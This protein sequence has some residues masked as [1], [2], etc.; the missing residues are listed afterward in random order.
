MFRQVHYLVSVKRSGIQSLFPPFSSTVEASAKGEQFIREDGKDA[1]HCKADGRPF[2]SIQ[3]LKK[4]K[5]LDKAR[6]R[7]LQ[8]GTLLVN[9]VKREDAGNYTCQITQTKGYFTKQKEIAVR[10][11]VTGG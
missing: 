2:P 1:L 11:V 9:S 8:N 5:S 10:V 4:G 3:W 7:H 6:F